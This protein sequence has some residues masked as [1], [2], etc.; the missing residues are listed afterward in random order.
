MSR[1]MREIGERYNNARRDSI[2]R[3]IRAGISG[4]EYYPKV[5]GDL[6]LDNEEDAYVIGVALSW[7]PDHQ[8][9]AAP[10]AKVLSEAAR[11]AA[12]KEGE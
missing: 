8:R 4:I 3:A 2:I 11:A 10:V 1:T 6:D 5:W 12:I 7:L 9:P